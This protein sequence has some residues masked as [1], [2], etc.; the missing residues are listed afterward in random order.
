M[1]KII[2]YFLI[3]MFCFGCTPLIVSATEEMSDNILEEHYKD[4]SRRKS[5]AHDTAERIRAMGYD[6]SH[7]TIV[8]AKEKW[9]EA[10]KEF[11]YYKSFENKMEEYPDATTI[12]IYL[13]DEG[14]N[15][16]ACAG[17]IGNMMVEC[18]DLTLNIIPERY[19]TYNTNY[20]G[21]CMW[22]GVYYPDVF[23]MSL[24]EQLEFLMSN[25]KY[26]I[27][28]FGYLYYQGFTYD[29][30]LTLNNVWE[31]TMSF[32]KS[33]ERCYSDSY[34]FRVDCAYTAYDYFV[35]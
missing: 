15:D 31:T 5:E 11:L 27:D 33:Y 16:Y 3:I 22:Y 9:W 6:E 19:G 24:Y 2:C 35:N 29:T 26:E 28:T 12:W 10:E 17:I 18:G 1:K 21:I 8:K 34:Q 14:F 4:I 20:Y 25:I 13:H 7:P 30:F 23:G 32:C